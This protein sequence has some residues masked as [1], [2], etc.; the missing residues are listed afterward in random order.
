MVHDA[1]LLS[2]HGGVGLTMASIRQQYWV[3]RLR[4]LAKKV[5][6]ACYGYKKFQVSAFSNPPVGNLPTDRTVGSAAFEVVGVD[7]AGPI[8][9]KIKPKKEGKAYILL[10]ACSLTRAVHLQLL[11]NQTTEEFIK[12]LKHFIARRGRPRK[13]YSDNGRTFVAAAK[14]LNRLMK[15]EQL[16]DYLA[17]Q[18]IRWQFNLSQPPWRGGGGGGGSLRDLWAS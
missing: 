12:H 16:Q 1:H 14:S 2:L 8:L 11:P 7:F 18:G 5:I 4:Q 3:P 15:S 9:Y 10:F 13:I 6:R 17:H